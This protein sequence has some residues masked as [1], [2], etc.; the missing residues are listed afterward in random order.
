MI[1]YKAVYIKVCCL[2]V[3]IFPCNSIM[4]DTSRMASEIFQVTTF[5]LTSIV[6]IVLKPRKRIYMDLFLKLYGFFGKYL[7]Q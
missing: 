1:R 4:K 3:I 2:W 7:Y 5:L 6:S